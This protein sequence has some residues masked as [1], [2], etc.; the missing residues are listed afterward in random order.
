MAIVRYTHRP[1]IVGD[2][3]RFNTCGLGEVIVYFPDGE[4][5]SE[6]I[7]E[8]DVLLDTGWVSM[9]EAF[10]TKKLIPDNYSLYFRE[11]L[12]AAEYEKGWY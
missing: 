4:A 3:S 1:E 5:T 8:L 10:K 7:S 2:T 6:E 11:P 12:T 9:S